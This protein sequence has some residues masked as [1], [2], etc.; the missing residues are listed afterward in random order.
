MSPIRILL[1]DD[2]PLF[3]DGLQT[4]LSMQPDLEIVGEAAN[5]LTVLQFAINL[6]PDVVLMDVHLPLMDGLTATRRLKS[7]HP[8][9]HVI[10]LTT[11]DAPG[12]EE[13]AVQAGAEGLL[14]KDVSAE[15][16]I[17]LIRQGYYDR[18]HSR[19]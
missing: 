9:C 11:F 10:V 16:L 2:D 8:S 1:V 4:I 17:K 3:R 13:K 5:G 6:L 18:S 7:I 14:L 15:A 19:I 12:L